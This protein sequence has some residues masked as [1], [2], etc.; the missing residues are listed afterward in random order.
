ML[1]YHLENSFD[2]LDLNFVIE[3]GKNINCVECRVFSMIC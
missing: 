3:N 2:D 1:Y